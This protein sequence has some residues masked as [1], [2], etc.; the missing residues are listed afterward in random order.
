MGF[1][2]HP[3]RWKI[4]VCVSKENFP[5]GAGALHL[6]Q[7]GCVSRA[8]P[9]GQSFS[10]AALAP[11]EL[12]PEAV[13]SPPGMEQVCTTVGLPQSGKFRTSY[14]QVTHLDG[15]RCNAP[16]PNLSCGWLHPH[17]S[18]T[19]QSGKFRTPYDQVTHLDGGRCNAPAPNLPCG[20]M[21]DNSKWEV[22]YF[23]RPSYALG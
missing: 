8:R 17:N 20:W 9:A 2:P 7:S 23:V 10:P 16:A 19:T 18:G 22:S 14:D 15:G 11:A 4:R 13:E 12:V 3:K 5:E 1:P 21:G 6:P